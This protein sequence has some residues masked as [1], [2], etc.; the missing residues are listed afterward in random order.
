MANCNV[1]EEQGV[2][3]VALSGDVD[4]ESSPK[5]R[6][7]LLDSVGMKKA[8]LVDMSD[9]SYIDSSGVASL[10]EAYQIARSNKTSFALANVSS[11]ALRVLELARL[12]KV[13]TIHP[14]LADGLKDAG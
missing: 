7:T 2:T 10:V 12:D 9:V 13:F 3:V 8:V 6:G 5:I 4:M 11:S 1:R 14:S